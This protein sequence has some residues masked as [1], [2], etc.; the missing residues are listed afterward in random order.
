M[1]RK[2]C[3][4]K[5][6]DTISTLIYRA[7]KRRL[8][9]HSPSVCRQRASRELAS[10]TLGKSCRKTLSYT[11]IY[12][13]KFISNSNSGLSTSDPVEIYIY[14]VINVC[15]FVSFV[16]VEIRSNLLLGCVSKGLQLRRFRHC[17]FKVNF[18][19]FVFTFEQSYYIYI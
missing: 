15:S 17:F 18:N 1:P 10:T 5:L 16:T 11:Y 9:G 4:Q 8:R 14:W 12:I 6:R 19:L 3:D 2:Q 13:Y 7:S